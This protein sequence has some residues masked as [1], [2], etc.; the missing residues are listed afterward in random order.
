MTKSRDVYWLNICP[1]KKLLWQD[2]YNIRQYLFL[3]KG[4]WGEVGD[5][6]RKT[7]QECTL[8]RDGN[9]K[10]VMERAEGWGVTHGKRNCKKMLT[11][12]G[13]EREGKS[14]AK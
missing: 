10:V 12:V 5:R 2:K 6:E 1:T 7:E 11:K 14:K 3:L 8:V 13:G 9:F 4:C